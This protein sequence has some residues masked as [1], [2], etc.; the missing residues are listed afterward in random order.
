MATH[1]AR[2]AWSP[3]PG[4]RAARYRPLQLW[5]VPVFFAGLV[6][7]AA[8][9]VA[10]LLWHENDAGRVARDLAAARALLA[11]RDCPVEGVQAYLSAA[12]DRP[13]T[14]GEAHFL[15]GSAYVRQADRGEPGADDAWQ[16]ARAELEQAETLGVPEADRPR[17]RYRLA[18]AWYHTQGDPERVVAYL[19]E[20]ATADDPVEGYG[21]LTGAYLRLPQPDVP[22]A[23]LANEKQLQLPT[24]DEAVLAPARLLRGELLLRLQRPDEAREVL[25]FI[26]PPAAPDLVAVARSLRA[27]SYQQEGQWAVAAALWKEAVDD[28]SLSRQDAAEAR[29]NLGICWQNMGK[30]ADAVAAWETVQAEPGSDLAQAAT[31]RLAEL[32]LQD[33]SPQ[34]AFSD[35]ERLVQKVK[36]PA[37]WKNALVDLGKVRE[38]FERGCVIY[39]TVGRYDL[40][41]RLAE[42]YEPLAP[43]GVA[44]SLYAQSAEAA[45]RAKLEQAGPSAG[46]LVIENARALFREAGRKHEAALAAATTP[47][48]R[49][50]RLWRAADCYLRG[51]D[52]PPGVVMLERWLK[53][54]QQP[55][56]FG[57][58]CFRLGEAQRALHHDAEA[59]DAYNEAVGRP[60]PFACRAR[61][62]LAA[63][64][65]ARGE[66]DRAEEDLELN[67]KVLRTDPDAEALE[68]TLFE[69]G[70]L[71]CKR[72]NYRIAAERL[73]EALRQY[74]ASPR[75]PHGRFLLAECYRNLA[76]EEGQNLRL[77][78]RMTRT[79]EE[80]YQKQYRDWLEKAAL[81]YEE[82]TRTLGGRLAAGPLSADEESL[83]RQASFSAAECRFNRGEYRAA[84]A[85]YA[86]LV[87]RYHHRIEGL[88]ARAGIVQCYFAQGQPDEARKT[89]DGIQS[90]L[91]EM[92]E[93][94][95]KNSPGGWTKADWE[96]WLATASKR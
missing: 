81:S 44:A 3:G 67:R 66:W 58:A 86:P 56:R 28:R 7:L 17:Q 91:K 20:T 64:E 90:V 47:A 68:W 50:E 93:S 92:D 61:Y 4:G 19:A 21:L 6:A 27:R 48:D 72:H 45:A 54:G 63:L 73:H 60:G 87:V 29:Y 40:A 23:L 32:R 82:L 18:K 74:P 41:M 42:L 88:Q 75:V 1:T 35:L 15:L 8:V 80:H 55:E 25:K 65:I 62:E 26:K 59:I 77:S 34:A 78:E 79:T 53:A 51:G 94:A 10:R 95:F 37:D 13:A 57:E 24:L 11:R 84:V 38:V 83:Y 49:A 52:F 12:L 89:L 85:M 33:A 2:S 30:R 9:G 71:M 76:L 96:K 31:L 39:H 46:R 69:L 36:A 14:A 43:P 70:D 22:A 5:Q 16:T